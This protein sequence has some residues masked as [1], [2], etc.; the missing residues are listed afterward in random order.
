MNEHLPAA[1]I[2]WVAF[3]PVAVEL[4]RARFGHDKIIA[5]ETTFVTL[6]LENSRDNFLTQAHIVETKRGQV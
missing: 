4:P 2:S 5:W 6:A 1:L 3:A